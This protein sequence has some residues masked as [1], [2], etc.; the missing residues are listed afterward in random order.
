MGLKCNRDSPDC[1]GGVMGE[2]GKWKAQ[3]HVNVKVDLLCKA[4][5]LPLGCGSE[6][7]YRVLTLKGKHW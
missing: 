5:N 7:A 1:L 3:E 2:E 6:R 4:E